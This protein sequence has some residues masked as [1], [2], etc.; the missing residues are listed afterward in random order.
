MSQVSN[1]P[2]QEIILTDESYFTS[3]ISDINKAEK[4]IDLET[5]IFSDDEIGQ[6]VAHVLCAAAKR[7]VNVRV[8]VDGIGSLT[9]NYEMIQQMETAGITVRIFHP[10][11]FI[12][13]HWKHLAHPSSS[14]LIKI[15]DL[16]SKVNSRNHRKTCIIDHKI[17]YIGSANITKGFI[18]QSNFTRWR[19]TGVKLVGIDIS[20]LQYVFEKAFNSVS[21][22]KRF[23]HVFHQM[24]VEPII[25]LNDTFRR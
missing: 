2:H 12:I 21:L 1:A 24:N 20:D 19:D 3:L 6:E 23:D 18:R 25:R 5:Y 11:P 14:I 13:S 17:V 22:K 16:L 8:L 10:F 7:K 15:F 9:W 4:S